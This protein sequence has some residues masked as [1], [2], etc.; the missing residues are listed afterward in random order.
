L[1][2]CLDASL[3]WSINL[4]A[5]AV[6]SP[7]KGERYCSLVLG[8]R[9][10]PSASTLKSRSTHMSLKIIPYTRQ[11][12]I[13]GAALL[14]TATTSALA[15]DGAV[16]GKIAQLDVSAA[17]ENYGFRVMLVGAPTMCTGGVGWAAINTSAT[18]YQATVSLFY[19]AYSLGK[20]V[21]VYT[22]KD[23]NNYCVIGYVA[24]Q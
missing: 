9:I 10:S 11:C 24:L 7:G 23:A 8:G 14:L 4:R 16:T 1:I 5:R 21:T 20:N 13:A 12:V 17:G 19:L 2:C 6:T 3:G 22:T 15:W 18:N